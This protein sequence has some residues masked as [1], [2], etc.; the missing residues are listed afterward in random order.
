MKAAVNSGQLPS[1]LLLEHGKFD[2]E[3]IRSFDSRILVAYQILQDE[4]C[5]SCGVP[6]WY[7]ANEDRELAFEV[8]TSTCYG[9]AELETARE[10]NRKK[11]EGRESRMYGVTEYVRPYKDAG[12]DAY[13]NPLP[14]APLDSRADS[15]KA[16]AER[17]EKLANVNTEGLF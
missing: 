4:T 15:F 10:D 5:S 1:Y 7:G 13:G 12:T 6:A 17:A 11:Y 9:C 2:K 8:L 3:T 14:H 16:M